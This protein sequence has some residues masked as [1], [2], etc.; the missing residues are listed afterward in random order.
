MATSCTAF[1]EDVTSDPVQLRPATDAD[2]DAVLALLRDAN[3]EA[4]FVAREFTLALDGGRVIA[5]ARLRPLAGGAAEIA[6]VA[7]AR[8]RR[9]QGIGERLVRDVLAGAPGEVLALAMAPGFFARLGFAVLDATPP[10]LAPKAAGVCA[11][12]PFVPMRWRAGPGSAGAR[13]R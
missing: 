8:E 1:A 5:A 13:V 4:A 3:V 12:R 6:S 11:S 9:G 10:I 7:V 2:E